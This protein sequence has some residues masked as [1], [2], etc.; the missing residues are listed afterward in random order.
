VIGD[1]IFSGRC[2]ARLVMVFHLCSRPRFGAERGP[3]LVLRFSQF[4]A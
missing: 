4:F 3:F 1:R 2:H